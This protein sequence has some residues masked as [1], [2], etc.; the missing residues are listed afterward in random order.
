MAVMTQKKT[1][2]E[3]LKGKKLDIRHSQDQAANRFGA[4]SAAQAR[5]SAA[6][7]QGAGLIGKL[8]KQALTEKK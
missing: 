3:K 8:L 6:A 2:L 4:G 5:R 7:G 1:D